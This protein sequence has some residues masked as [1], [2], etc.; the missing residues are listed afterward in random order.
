[1]LYRS[2]WRE[3]PIAATVRQES[4]GSIYSSPLVV[5]GVVYFGSTDGNMYALD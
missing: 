1:M 3:D 5:D 2:T 4:V